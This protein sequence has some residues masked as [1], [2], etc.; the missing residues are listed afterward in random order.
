MNGFAIV[1]LNDCIDKGSTVVGITA[2]YI[3]TNEVNAKPF[4]E[5]KDCATGKFNGSTIAF[6]LHN[7]VPMHKIFD[8]YNW[9]LDIAVLEG[10]VKFGPIIELMG[11]SDFA[12]VWNITAG[13]ITI[14]HS[15]PRSSAWPNCVTW[16]GL[17]AIGNGH[18][19][20]RVNH[21]PNSPRCPTDRFGSAGLPLDKICKII[22]VS[23]FLEFAQRIL[24]SLVA[25]TT[26]EVLQFLDILVG[27]D[28]P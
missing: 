7:R 4:H 14:C 28:L 12:S 5:P 2:D 3:Q 23:G 27:L 20:P 22:D 10:N 1:I 26:Q 9:H 18:E 25:G 13:G 21:C 11:D 19:G 24:G 15:I 8:R 17:G 16:E 6:E